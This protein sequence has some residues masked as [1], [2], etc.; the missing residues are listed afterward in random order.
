MFEDSL[1]ESTGRIRTR[2]R[3]YAAGSLMFEA[4]LLSALILIP[5]IYPASLPSEAMST[6]LVAPPPPAAP[7][8]AFHAQMARAASPMQLVALFAPRLIPRPADEGMGRTAAPPGMDARIPEAGGDVPGAITLLGSVPPPPAVARTKASRPLRVSA[9]VAAGHVIVPIQPV[10]PAIA[11]EAHIQGT[12]VI[13]AV[14]SKE[15][16]VEQAHVVGGPSLL[17]QAALTAVERARYEPFRLNGEAVEVGTTIN[18]V[19]SLGQ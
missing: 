10:Y 4:A 7:A 17:V 14:I 16:L 3:W 19:F 2:S 9:G 13:E 18:V 11:R 15:G 8:Q 1:V 5:Y 6:L 12:V